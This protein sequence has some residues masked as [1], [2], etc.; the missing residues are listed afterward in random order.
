VAVCTDGV[1]EVRS[2]EGVGGITLRGEFASLEEVYAVNDRCDAK[3]RDW[4]NIDEDDA[5]VKI[6]ASSGTDIY[7]SLVN[8]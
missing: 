8:K 3:L 2:V 4:F 6:S 1:Y 5:F 7:A